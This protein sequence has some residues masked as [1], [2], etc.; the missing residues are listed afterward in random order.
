[1]TSWSPGAAPQLL[2]LATALPGNVIEQKI[3]SEM[4]RAFFGHRIARYDVLARVFASTGIER[5]YS[6]VP[7]T[8]FEESH[9]WPE[10]TAAYIEGASRLFEDVTRKALA[11]AGLVASQIDAV[12]TVSSTGV[13]TPSLEARVLPGL[14]FRSDVRRTPIFGLGCAGGV[15]GFAHASRVAASEPGTNVLLVTLELCTL[16]FRMDRATKP[17]IVSAALFGDGAAAAIFRC[18]GDGK[19]IGRV[20]GATEHLWANTIDIMGWSTDPAGLGVI[21]SRSLPDFVA[22]NYRTEYDRALERLG[23]TPT[24]I[25]TVLC[26]PGGTKVL[27]AIESSLDVPLG[28]LSIERSV[29]RDYG[30]MSSPTVLFVLER[31]LAQGLTG[32]A[33]LAALGPG[34]TASFATLHVGNG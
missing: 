29:M 25:D 22:R 16:A 7:L 6:V 33:M 8:W 32:T 23:I 10:R 15:S 4:A 34:F 31:A 28:T 14:G 17:D 5:R 13:A 26:H 12:V 24:D 9:D 18:G 1:L 3:A 21:L 2:S 20:G 27:E 30:N 19:A 11:A